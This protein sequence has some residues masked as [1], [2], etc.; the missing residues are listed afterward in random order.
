[1][2]KGK[3]IKNEYYK[4][5]TQNYIQEQ[6]F[7]AIVIGISNAMGMCHYRKEI[8]QLGTADDFEGSSGGVI[9]ILFRHV[10]GGTEKHR[11]KLSQ[12]CRCLGR[13]LKLSTPKYI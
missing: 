5:L 10:P 9:D 8:S 11:G 7:I 13:G 3:M 6:I 4:H 12:H 2:L 1:M